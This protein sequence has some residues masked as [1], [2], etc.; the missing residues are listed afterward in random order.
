MMHL[1]H[2]FMQLPKE[3][4]LREC[5]TQEYEADVVILE[6]LG[7]IKATSYVIYIFFSRLKKARKVHASNYAL[8]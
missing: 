2:D 8:T 7:K 3:L 4:L 5:G 6:R 1:I